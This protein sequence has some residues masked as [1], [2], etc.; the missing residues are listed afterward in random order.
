[1]LILSDN[2]VSGAVTAIQRVLESPEWT[3]FLV[4]LDLRFSEFAETG[5]ARDASE[6]GAGRLF[7]P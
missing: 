4:A 6:R 5:L 7:I 1:M 3:E 2:D